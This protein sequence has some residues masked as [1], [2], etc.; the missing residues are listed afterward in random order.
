[1][2]SKSNIELTPDLK[3]K[4]K[5]LLKE[6]VV[7]SHSSHN[8]QMIK[9]MSGRLNLACPY[10]GDSSR[11]DNMKRGNMFWDTLQYHCFNCDYHTNIYYFLKDFGI[12]MP[13]KMDAITLIDYVKSRK[14]S[15]DHSEKF[16]PFVYEKILELS[17][18]TEDFSKATGAK[19]IQIGDWIWF[20]LKERLLHKK[21]DNFLFNPKDQRLWI[22]NLS[23]DGRIIGAQCRRMRG[24]GSRYL[25]YD[26]S[27]IHESILNKPI[28][29]D[30]NTRNQFDNVST[31]FGALR[32]NFQNP[33]TIF[34]GPLDAMFMANSIA[35]CTVGRD[36]T[37]LDYID[38]SR[39]M[40]D[41]DDAGLKKSIEKLK[42][43]KK[44][45]MWNKYLKDKK[46]DKYNIKDLNDLV[47]VCYREKIK[48]SLSSLDEYFT[49]NKLDL[50]YV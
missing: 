38:S 36:T 41:N 1:M 13:D 39:Y 17:V 10:C 12:R 27:K 43:G 8:K 49:N 15:A 5:V 7:K 32:V 47:K 44:V 46:I 23:H 33:V 2:T 21:L 24:K 6:V 14:S 9:D 28:E 31:L 20:K 29:M 37:K 40:L 26:L 48:L 19:P 16:T 42:A 34:E 25:T 18:K 45:F 50:R 11:D 30:D 3:E 4:I 35:L 22:L